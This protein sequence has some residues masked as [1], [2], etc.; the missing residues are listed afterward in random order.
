MAYDIK[1][2]LIKNKLAKTCQYNGCK[3]MYFNYSI[4]IEKP[5]NKKTKITIN[6]KSEDNFNINNGIYL[7]NSN[8]WKKEDCETR[9]HFIQKQDETEALEKIGLKH[10]DIEGIL[11]EIKSALLHEFIQ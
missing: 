11:K 2:E 7:E 5:I 8:D 6:Y 10:E 1:D 3:I 9:Y 4:I